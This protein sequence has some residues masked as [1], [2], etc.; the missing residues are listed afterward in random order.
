MLDFFSRR[1]SDGGAEQQL[2]FVAVGYPKVGN[3]W[4]RVTLGRYVQKLANLPELPLFELGDSLQLLKAIGPAG[5]GY[6]THAPLEWTAQTASEL[7]FENVVR[8]FRKQKVILLVRHPLDAVVSHYMHNSYKREKGSRFAGSLDDFAEN[9]VFGLDKLLKFYEVWR[10]GLGEVRACLLWRYEDARQTPLNSLQQVVRFLDL[11]IDWAAAKEAVD[12]SS[13]EKMKRVES[14]G[15]S[16]AYK[17]SGFEV[18]G[19]GDRK[20][21][22]AFHVRNGQVGDYKTKFSSDRLP[23]Y[24]RAVSER[25]SNFFGY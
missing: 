16:F 8:P 25:L 11:P 2:S 5:V 23:V 3:T 6:F 20:E 7:N 18:F 22:N 13:F 21:P 17:S 10:E 24:E 15:V 1:R 4:L 14:S 9:Q 19:G 12:F